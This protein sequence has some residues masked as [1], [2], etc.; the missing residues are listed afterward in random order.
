LIWPFRL[1][2]G[3]C[4]LDD[5]YILVSNNKVWVLAV[6]WMLVCIFLTFCN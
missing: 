6:K 3:T 4:H 1:I 2:Q 5:I